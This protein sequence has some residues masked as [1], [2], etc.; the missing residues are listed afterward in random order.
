M[1]HPIEEFAPAPVPLLEVV[2]P[3]DTLSIAFVVAALCAAAYLVSVVTR[4]R[5]KPAARPHCRL[6]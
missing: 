5:R 3:R 1:I 2:E 6:L 4:P